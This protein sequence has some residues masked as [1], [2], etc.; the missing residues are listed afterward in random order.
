MLGGAY[1]L[2][3]RKDL[4]PVGARGR[5]LAPGLQFIPRA[6]GHPKC[7][8]VQGWCADP[9]ILAKVQCPCLPRPLGA[10]RGVSGPPRASQGIPKP[11][12]VSQGFPWLPG[13]SQGFP[14]L[15]R[16][17][18][19]F[20]GLPGASQCFPGPPGASPKDSQGVPRAAQGFPGPPRNS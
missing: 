13:G 16:A 18:Q 2:K 4:G 7:H 8:K 9:R 15:P 19:G 17:S 20:S 3:R 1:S 11:P 14:R 5:G 10:S 6:Q 12:M